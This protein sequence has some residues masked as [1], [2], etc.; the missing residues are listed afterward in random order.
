MGHSLYGLGV[1]ELT[2]TFDRVDLEALRAEYRY[3][4]NRTREGPTRKELTDYLGVIVTRK[5]LSS[6]GVNYRP[7]V[8]LTRQ[9]AKAVI[10]EVR[11]RSGKRLLRAAEEE[12]RR[13]R[14]CSHRASEDAQGTVQRA[15]EGALP[16]SFGQ[17]TGR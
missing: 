4:S 2:E 13:R 15:Q 6:A 8:S 9:E 14:T 16:S 1:D 3:D 7:G 10:S 11:R 17:H 12:E 5:I